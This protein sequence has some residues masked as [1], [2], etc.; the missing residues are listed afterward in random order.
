VEK[1]GFKLGVKERGVYI[2]LF[3]SVPEY[4]L[5]RSRR[6]G[7]TCECEPLDALGRTTISHSSC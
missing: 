7:K 5:C 1:I 6:V 4:S 2:D 3:R